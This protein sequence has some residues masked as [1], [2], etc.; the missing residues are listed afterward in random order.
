[1]M[2]IMARAHDTTQVLGGVGDGGRFASAINTFRDRKPVSRQSLV[3]NPG[4]GLALKSEKLTV[5]SF[6]QMVRSR[7]RTSS[8]HV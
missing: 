4:V 3:A 7:S 5:H 2:T 6:E 1:M 8:L